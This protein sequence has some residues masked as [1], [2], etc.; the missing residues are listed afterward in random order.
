V[1]GG[2]FPHPLFPTYA[3]PWLDDVGSR[4]ILKNI[5]SIYLN[6]SHTTNPDVVDHL[7][8]LVN[9]LGEMDQ[10]PGMLKVQTMSK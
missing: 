7:Q 10:S 5:F 8:A 3:A 4:I 2:E 1:G 6:N 9:W